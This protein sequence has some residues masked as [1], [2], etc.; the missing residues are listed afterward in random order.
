MSAIKR[1]Q[2][3]IMLKWLKIKRPFQMKTAFDSVDFIQ[4][5][6]EKQVDQKYHYFERGVPLTE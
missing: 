6:Q 5:F 1:N 2:P 4:E 3:E